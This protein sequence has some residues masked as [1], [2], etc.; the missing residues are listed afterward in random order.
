MKKRLLIILLALLVG[1]RTQ[2]QIRVGTLLLPVKENANRLQLA[3]AGGLQTPQ[4]NNLDLNFDGTPDLLVFDRS[5]S[6]LLLFINNNQLADTTYTYAPELKSFF[7]PDLHSWVL[8]RDYNCDGKPDIFTA[9][10][11]DNIRVFKNTS[12]NGL[13]SFQLVKTVIQAGNIPV[14]I[15]S[16]D[17]PAI[18][19]VDNDGD[20]DIA[21]FTSGSDFVSYFKNMRVENNQ[22]CSADT[23]IYQ[24]AT[25]CWG[26]FQE[27]FFNSSIV[28]GVGCGGNREAQKTQGH[29]GS[30]LLLF[31]ADNDGDKEAV[32]GDISSDKVVFLQNGGSAA[33]ANMVSQSISWPPANPVSLYSYPAAY[34]LDVD[35]DQIKD[36]VIT[37][38][39]GGKNFEQVQFYKNTGTNALPNFTFRKHDLLGGEML[40]FG[41][42]AYPAFADLD[43]DGD[44]DLVV[45]NDAYTTSATNSGSQVAYYQN[46]GTNTAPKYILITRD[47]AGLRSRN[48]FSLAPAFGDLDNDGDSDMLL[49]ET[50]GFVWYFRNDAVGSAPAQFTLVSQ[51]FLNQTVGANS[52]PTLADVD[53]D[54]DLD[55]V[56]GER[57]GNLNFFRNSGTVSNPAFTLINTTFGNVNVRNP[58]IGAGYATPAIADMDQNNVPDL[59]VGD[60]DGN[61]HLYPNFTANLTGT[62]I[63]KP[64]AFFNSQT[65]AVEIFRPGRKVAP[66]AASLTVDNLPDLVVGV[67]RGGLRTF[68]NQGLFTGLNSRELAAKKL[69]SYPNPFQKE[70]TVKLDPGAGA[71][72]SVT[73]LLGRTQLLKK[74]PGGTSE[75][76]LELAHLEAGVYILS[77]TRENDSVLKSKILKIN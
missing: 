42:G 76:T 33:N 59:L 5:D 75:I 62:F 23:L 72:L 1:N 41:A 36:L 38:N 29:S 52:T 55:L 58:L 49:G 14:D 10:N 54:G 18:I 22:L 74:L 25:R 16:A 21:G 64:F 31:D 26:L 67:S 3:F 32:I 30:T 27:G 37:P 45:G 56:V 43:R 8:V 11:S 70:L 71:V 66:A 57:N 17:L 19:D 6:E 68:Q 24:R 44:L 2:A 60:F 65:N 20:L 35:N 53:H 47:L 48:L 7:P 9:G 28:L 50:Q 40:E 69:E 4:F 46:V 39:A 34:F 73:D 15:P 77:L 13:L 51:N 12:Q 63:E 61:V